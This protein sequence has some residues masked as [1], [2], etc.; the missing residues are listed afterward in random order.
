MDANSRMK[1]LPWTTPHRPPA[2]R[3]RHALMMSTGLLIAPGA[4]IAQV[5]SCVI[6]NG[7]CTIP[8]GT[9]TQ[10]YVG[11]VFNTSPLNIVNDG[12]LVIAT[13]S[14]RSFL[15]ALQTI[16]NGP[17][18]ANSSNDDAGSGSPSGN[19]TLTNNGAVTLTL[20]SPIP[21]PGVS[22][23]VYAAAIGGNGGNYTATN[24]KHDGGDAAGAGTA[25]LNN[26]ATI[27]VNQ[28][29]SGN[30]SVFL[31]GAGLL[32]DSIG[33]SG[34]NVTSEGPDQ[35]GNPTYSNQNGRAG[36]AGNTATLVNSG[37]VSVSFD[38]PWVGTGYWGAAGLAAPPPPH[39]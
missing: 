34:G 12:T 15:G 21:N 2:R 33:G 7:V 32:V 10:P 20:F 18:G 16:A 8:A 38:Y 22:N 23:A 35:N 28:G 3:F 14:A 24:A 27:T 30:P 5:P 1:K 17:S 29:N 6:S 39:P 36:A 4:A 31:S 26:I 37:I 11:Q 25:T 19:M 9:Y 13:S